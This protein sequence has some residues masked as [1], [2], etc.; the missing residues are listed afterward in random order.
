MRSRLEADEDEL[1]EFDTWLINKGDLLGRTFPYN[2]S[3]EV[4]DYSKRTPGSDFCDT[5]RIFEGC[6]SPDEE[7]IVDLFEMDEEWDQF[8]YSLEWIDE[9]Y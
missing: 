6:V 2:R 8:D 3:F 5:N 1:R 4:M 9:A 7:E